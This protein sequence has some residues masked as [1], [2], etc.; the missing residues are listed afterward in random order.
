MVNR[1]IIATTIAAPNDLAAILPDPTTASG[2]F[3]TM[4]L[5]P[6]TVKGRRPEA[7]TK[8]LAL[9]EPSLCMKF[10][11]D[12]VQGVFRSEFIGHKQCNKSVSL[13]QRR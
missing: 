2:Q 9:L 11:P 5:L 3:I 1:V 12:N 7:G 10:G 8:I 4:P 6:L 13:L